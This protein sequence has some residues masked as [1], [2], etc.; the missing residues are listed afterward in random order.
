ME[1]PTPEE[2]MREQEEKLKAKYGALKPKKKLIQK[3]VKYFDSADWALQ[4]QDKSPQKNED[5]SDVDALPPKIQAGTPPQ[6]KS[7]MKGGV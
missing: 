4:M 1:E 6:A 7:P 5:G 2:I 3:D